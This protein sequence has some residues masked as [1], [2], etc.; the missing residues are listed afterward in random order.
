MTPITIHIGMNKTGT[1]A[2]Q[3]A[4]HRNRRALLKAGFHYPDTGLGSLS[5]GAGLHYRFSESF[6]RD[7]ATAR[8]ITA[9]LL[10]EI[11]ER[12]ADHAFVSSE[13]LVEL[14]D[15]TALAEA[16]A[17]RDVRVLVYL[18]RH[19]HWLPSLFAQAVKTRPQPPWGP[20][21]EDFI[22]FVRTRS[23]HYYRFGALLERWSEAF[24]RDAM[25]VRTYGP[26]GT[27]DTVAD[28]FDLFGI[29]PAAVPGLTL[30][31]GRVNGAPSRRQLAAID[32][33]QRA[34]IPAFD[35]IRLV[36]RILSLDDGEKPRRLMTQATARA[37]VEEHA[38]DYAEIARTY[39]GRADG[40]LFDEPMPEPGGPDRVA[41]W[42]GEGITVMTELLREAV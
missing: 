13:F 4:L 12:N 10:R 18:R 8:T 35:R 20:S 38:A 33:L 16:F 15:L 6:L 22:D 34:R 11:D 21:I 5:E 23:T 40:I 29:D 17:G 36:D 3:A 41:L 7:A 31:K 42:P 28:V 2:L 1:S 39:L 19:D 27:T 25:I 14:K 32:H 24:G 9:A 30:P 37:L 26:G